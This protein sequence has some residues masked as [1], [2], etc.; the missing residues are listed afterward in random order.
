M[1]PYKYF[2][3]G[4]QRHRSYQEGE[5]EVEEEGRDVS[6][7]AILLSVA[8]DKPS[9]VGAL[10]SVGGVWPERMVDSAV[11]WSVGEECHGQGDHALMMVTLILCQ[12]STLAILMI[13]KKYIRLSSIKSHQGLKQTVGWSH[14]WYCLVWSPEG[15]VSLTFPEDRLAQISR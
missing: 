15:L 7:R 9:V 10:G 5:G 2:L 13:T 6:L 14:T 11:Q 4:S 3:T 1:L 8:L 12:Y